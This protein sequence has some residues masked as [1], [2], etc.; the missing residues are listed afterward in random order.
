MSTLFFSV[1][2]PTYNRAALIIETIES[3]RLQTFS[4]FEVIVVDDGS[5][6]D[7][8]DCLKILM[9]QDARIKYFLK[10]NGERGAARNFGIQEAKGKFALFF[11]SDDLMKPHYLKLLYDTI[12]ENP[13][14]NFIAAKFNFID[15]KG[16]ETYQKNGLKTGWYDKVP[17]LVGNSLACNFAIR[18]SPNSYKPFVPDREY[19]SIEDWLFLLANLEKNKIYIVD[20]V[21]LSMRAHDQ[22]S[23]LNNIKVIRAREKAVIWAFGNLSLRKAEMLKL[24]AWSHYYCGIHYY[25]DNNRLNAVRETL[26]AMKLNCIN[27]KFLILLVKSIIG[28]QV[29]LRLGIGKK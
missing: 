20:E 16:E 29:F 7:T 25:L 17:F 18:L 4:H 8:F 22:R 21:A 2:I 11:D 23:M 5:T 26:L 10:G 15:E 3:I 6:D 27:P 1:I 13:T 12:Q 24:K 28:R 9:T 14:I 19:A